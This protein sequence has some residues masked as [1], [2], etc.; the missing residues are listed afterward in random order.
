MTTSFAG[1]A[2]RWLLPTLVAVACVAQQAPAPRIVTLSAPDGTI[3][4]G[5]YFASPRPGPGVILLHQ[6]DQQRKLWDPLGESLAAAGI[7][8]L[9]IDYRGFGESGGAR[10]DK[11]PDQEQNK[12]IEQTWPGD[13]DAA[14]Q[15]VLAQTGVDRRTIGAGGASCGVSNSIK[16]AQRHPEVKALLL[17][18]GP[19]GREGRRFVQ[20]SKDL[21]IFTA[22]ADDDKYGPQNLQM[23][24]LYSVSRN[25]CSRFERYPNGGHGAEM[26]A[27]HKEFPG[28]ISQWFVACLMHKPASIPRTN[29]V[30]LEPEVLRA[31]DLIDRPGDGGVAQIAKALAKAR[32]R[33]PKTTLFPEFIVNLLGYEHLQIADTKGAVE[34][35]KLNA[36]AYPGSP[37]AYDSLADAYLADGQKD[38][39]LQNAKKAVDLLANDTADTEQRRTA[40]RDN[41]GLKIKQLTSPH[42]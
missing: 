28:I 13:I 40:I 5:T 39:A 7:N 36:A 2:S 16:L 25:P 19:P 24:W 26:F 8:V 15:Y 9:T 10:F 1:N 11:L 14:F 23:Q 18:S 29:G 31:L 38:L 3:L 32:E 41:A 21:P 12:V 20:A 37:N 42:P 27:V 17:L 6:C 30:A 34:I 4:K 22:A 33:D 35:L